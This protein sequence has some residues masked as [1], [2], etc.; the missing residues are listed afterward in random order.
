MNQNTYK[1]AC[2]EY[3]TENFLMDTALSEVT[4]QCSLAVA[5]A[6]AY[7]ETASYHFQSQFLSV[8]FK[9]LL[10]KKNYFH[11]C[12]SSFKHMQYPADTNLG[13]VEPQLQNSGGPLPQS[14]IES[15]CICSI[16][17][18]RIMEPH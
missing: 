2:H 7:I 8:A 10:K 6:H 12:G 9:T 13:S 14:L 17:S 16:Y 11:V 18:A 4:H 15:Y 1:I 5:P 3:G